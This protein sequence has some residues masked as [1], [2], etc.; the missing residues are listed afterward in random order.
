MSSRRVAS[1]LAATCLGMLML[2]AGPAGAQQQFFRIGSGFAGTYPVFG[3]KL[4]EQVNKHLTDVR[5]STVPGGTEQNLIKLQRGEIEAVLSYT[6]E[7]AQVAEGKG[8]LQKA[9][10]PDLRHLMGLYGSYHYVLF[11]KDAALQSLADLKAKPY[12]VW[13]GTK[14]SV[15]WSLNSAALGA[16]GV[17]LEDITKVGGVINTMS[18]QNLTQAFQDGQIDV[19]FFAGPSPVSLLLQLDKTSGFRMFSFDEAGGK[20]YNEI[21][22]GTSMGAVKP[23]TYS[24]QKEE[25][26]VPYVFNQLVVSAKLS[27]DVAYRLTKMLNEE[28]KAFH[29]LF[30]GSEEVLPK[31]ALAHNRIKIHPGAEK[32]FRETGQLK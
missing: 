22:P 6:F 13:M 32:Y 9:P 7:A 1:V 26:R 25:V 2:T 30:P 19:G 28:Y 20:R 8:E 18:Y 5:A 27:D 16:Y 29:G 11:K 10:A 31:T 4:A 14:A 15:F 24:H 17:S 12:R 23:G 3:A 21:L